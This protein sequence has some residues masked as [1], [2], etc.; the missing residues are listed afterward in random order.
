MERLSYVYG[1]VRSWR[2][3]TSLGIDPIGSTSTCSFSCA[4]CQLGK[5]Q[6]VTTEIKTYVPTEYIIEDLQALEAS[7][8]FVYE[9]LDVITFAGSGE[10]TLAQNLAQ[11]IDAIRELYKDRKKQVPISILTNATMFNDSLVRERALHADLISLKLD[12]PNDEILS[13]VN[14]PAEG[15][16]VASIVSGITM[17]ALDCQADTT[18]QLQI[19]IMP[20]WLGKNEYLAEMAAVIRDL[21]INK[22]Q[23][24][25]PTRAKPVSKTG[26]YWIDTRGNHYGPGEADDIKPEYIEFTELPVITKEQAFALEDTWRELLRDS[27]PELEIVNVYKR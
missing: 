10:P 7:G 18:L 3:G 15:V 21:G 5:I 17:L 4:Y 6:K 11:M 27:L 9:D 22:L 1:P 16:S 12:A 14:Q 20:K 25:T 19:M 8:G 26:D 24:N 23:I 2:S 13:S